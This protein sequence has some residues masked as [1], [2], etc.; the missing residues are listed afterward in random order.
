MPKKK[1][2]VKKTAVKKTATKKTKKAAAK[3]KKVAAKKPAAKKKGPPQVK[4][5][6]STVTVTDQ[7]TVVVDAT[8]V[9]VTN[10]Q[11]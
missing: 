8:V 2:T 1:K 6:A 3:P 5:V 4:P 7:G 11:S 9:D 10:Q